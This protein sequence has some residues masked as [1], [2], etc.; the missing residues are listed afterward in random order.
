MVQCPGHPRTLTRRW[1]TIWLPSRA[2]T[3]QAGLSVGE[4]LP[5]P[6][7]YLSVPPGARSALPRLQVQPATRTLVSSPSTAPVPA[8]SLCYVPGVKRVSG[9]FL[10]PSSPQPWCNTTSRAL[11]AAWASPHTSWYL[12]APQTL[13]LWMVTSGLVVLLLPDTDAENHSFF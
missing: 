3:F 13:I 1:Q 2:L 10:L 8:A 4:V 7:G 6:R 5:V 11:A 12:F 9:V